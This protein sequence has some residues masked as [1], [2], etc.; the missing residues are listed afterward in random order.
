MDAVNIEYELL[1]RTPAEWYGSD[2]AVRLAMRL[3]L[4]QMPDGG[5]QTIQGKVKTAPLTSDDRASLEEYRVQQPTK[6]GYNDGGTT[7][8]VEGLAR[9]YHATMQRWIVEHIEGGLRYMLDSQMPNGGW[10]LFWP[11]WSEMKYARSLS[12]KDM[13]TARVAETL[14]KVGAGHVLYD[15]VDERLRAP[16][17]EGAAKALDLILRLQQCRGGR[18]TGWC[19]NYD[20]RTLEPMAGR[21]F[22]PIGVDSIVTGRMVEYLLRLPETVRAERAICDAVRSAMRW[23]EDVAIRGI[24][25]GRKDTQKKHP[26]DWH[27]LFDDE[28]RPCWAR[29]YGLDDNLPVYG[30][31][32]GGAHRSVT[33]RSVV[34]QQWQLVTDP[35]KC[36]RAGG[37]VM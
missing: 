24:R 32:D 8:E 4:M 10:R 36:L 18:R 12:F 13:A 29:V 34:G 28:A 25:W 7:N 15:F 26:T 37:V 16:A 23:L 9:V 27:V 5:W 1:T 14:G 3:A 35:G 2:V 33:Q 21:A 20:A 17:A 6:S 19:L 30:D 11:V 31:P 22:E